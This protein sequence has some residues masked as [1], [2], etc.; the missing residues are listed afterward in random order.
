MPAPTPGGPNNYQEYKT[1]ED[2]KVINEATG[3]CVKVTVAT[4]KVCPAGQYLNILTG[5]CNKIQENKEKTCKDGYYLNPETGRCRKIVKNEGTNYSI[6]PESYEEKSSFIAL[7]AVI[8]VLVVGLII[9]VYEFRTEIGK[10]FGKVFRRS[11]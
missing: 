9:V 1:C 11:R 7:Y 6:K 2:G 8:G 3:N 4:E 10:L 5:R